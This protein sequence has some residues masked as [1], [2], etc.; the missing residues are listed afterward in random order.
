MAVGVTTMALL[1]ACA[2]LAGPLV[3]ALACG[4]LGLEALTSMDLTALAAGL[5]MRTPKRF[6]V[7]V[8]V[9]SVHEEWEAPPVHPCPPAV[10]S[11]SKVW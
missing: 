2:G 5:L 1:L 3:L 7:R 4:G 10:P 6:A 11:V 8:V 9:N